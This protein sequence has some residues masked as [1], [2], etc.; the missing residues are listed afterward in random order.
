L[1]Q[2]LKMNAKHSQL[3][4]KYLVERRTYLR[5]ILLLGIM[6]LPIA[7]FGIG[8]RIP[9]QDPEAIARGNAF[10][11]TA[12][13]PAAIY[14]N[15]AGITQLP[16]QNIQVGVLN[17]LGINTHYEPPSGAAADTK[18][19][20][21]PVPQV[22][23]T[24]SPTD[25]P[26][27]FGLGLYA[28]FGL[29][30]NWPQDSGFRSLAIQA[31]LQFITLNP[32]IAWKIH[33]KL[34]LAIGP[35]INYS[36]IMFRR[37]LMTATDNL[38]FEGDD[39]SYGFNAGLL[40]QPHPKWSIGANYRSATTMDY[41]GTTTYNPG[42]GAASAKTT[43]SIPFP[44]SAS[45]GVSFRPTPK[46]NIEADVDWSGW[47]T[48]N[49][50]MLNGTKNIF[51]VNLPLQ[52]NWQDSWLYELGV[53]RYFDN[54]WYASAGYFY[55]TDTTSSKYFTPFVPDTKLHVG[56]LG[57]GHKGE[58][59]QW[60]LAGQIIAG[61]ERTIDNSQPNPF[62]GQSANGKYQ[63]FVPTVSFAVGYHF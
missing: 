34:S 35:T 15:P 6:I 43:A 8:L 4:L 12:D 28:P 56:S 29:E 26:I 44:Q 14:Y 25:I 33:P 2:K 47:S 19:K 38:K 59:W 11:A 63:L 50:V 46:W 20:V 49:T 62:T 53:T 39:F 13:N 52:L 55:S 42:G 32:V 22:Y 27:S 57:F 16:G 31:K 60:S 36:K 23:Y 37:G 24:F 17:Y 54:G 10:V 51:G 58:R 30:V 3:R 45:G 5:A 41:S 61:P 48:V 18:F 1:K 9:N 21:L 7:T 40:W